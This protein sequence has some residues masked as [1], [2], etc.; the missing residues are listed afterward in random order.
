MS[1]LVSKIENVLLTGPLDAVCGANVVY[2]AMNG[3]NLGKYEDVR[4]LADNAVNSALMKVTDTERRMKVLEIL[5]EMVIAYKSIK[6]LRAIKSLNTDKEAIQEKTRE[7]IE[8]NYNTLKS[9]LSNPKTDSDTSLY[10]ALKKNLVNHIDPGNLSWRDPEANMVLSDKSVLVEKLGQRQ[11]RV[12][13]E[14]YENMKCTLPE[15]VISNRNIVHDK[16]WKEN[17][18][19]LEKRAERILSVLGDIWNNPAFEN[20]TTRKEQSEGTYITDVVIPLLR[21]SLE[22]MPNGN[23]CLSTAERQSLASKFRRNS[24]EVSKERMGK[25]PD[26]MALVNYGGRINELVYAECSRIICNDT[27]KS[28]DEVKLWRETLDG[29]SFVNLVCRPLNN[30]FGI[31]GVQ[32]AGEDIYLNVLVNDAGGLS[33]YFHIDHAE[34]PLTVKSPRRVKPLLR[35]LLTL[36]NIMIVNKSLLMQALEQAISNPPRNVNPSPT[37]STPPYNN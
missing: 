25:K 29:I 36:R 30:Q 15:S 24:G 7:E 10:D 28:N 3:N 17:I 35:L 16:T 34:I 23:I 6:G 1:N 13:M 2:L 14:P 12:F 37:V 22:D 32:V 31:V 19:A 18:S 33:R 8:Q 9:K 4:T 26:A 21:A 27:K 20:S 5:A 11:K